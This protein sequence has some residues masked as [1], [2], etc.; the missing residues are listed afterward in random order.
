MA[1]NANSEAESQLSSVMSVDG[2][3]DVTV[4][5]DMFLSI[6]R[7]TSALSKIYTELF[8]KSRNEFM[9]ELCNCD[10]K[11]V[12]YVRDMMYRMIRRRTSAGQ[13][14]LLVDRK[15]GDNLKDKLIK[16]IYITA[17]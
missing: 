3:N 6:Q 14:G 1:G 17:L 12:R 15:S 9:P 7:A 10:V 5:D 2:V 8:V 11:E 16:D 4:P 13:L